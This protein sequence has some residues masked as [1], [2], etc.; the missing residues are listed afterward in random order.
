VPAGV[1]RVLVVEDDDDVLDV[2]SAMLRELGYQVL[3]ARNG[4]DALQMLKAGTR[5]DLLFSDVLM[6]QGITG[7]ELA[8]EA[9]RLNK[10]LKIL[11]TSGNAAYV[12][13]RYGAEDEFPI[14]GKPFRRADLAQYLRLVMR[15]HD[16]VSG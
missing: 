12:L 9:R 14:I 5:F 2:T 10:D 15:A 13:A 11:L 8:R 3:C 7:V 16:V 1:G 4:A 6:P